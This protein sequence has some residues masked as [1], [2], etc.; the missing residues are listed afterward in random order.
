MSAFTELT[1]SKQV[2]TSQNSKLSLTVLCWLPEGQK[3]RGAQSTAPPGRKSWILMPLQASLQVCMCVSE[4]SEEGRWVKLL[5][6]HLYRYISNYTSPSN[7]IFHSQTCHQLPQHATQPPPLMSM[8]WE[9]LRQGCLAFWCKSMSPNLCKNLIQ[10]NSHTCTESMETAI[11]TALGFVLPYLHWIHPLLQDLNYQQELD[12][13]KELCGHWAKLL[14][15][16]NHTNIQPS[17]DFPFCT[18]IFSSF[19]K[20]CPSSKLCCY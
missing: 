4:Q 10:R 7:W 11:C 6:A 15:V 13:Q 9:G 3:P 14:V 12:A 1:P 20:F 5:P 18:Q 2:S 19:A 17:L 8:G 16:R